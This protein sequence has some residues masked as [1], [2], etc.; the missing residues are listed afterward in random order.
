MCFIHIG[1]YFVT[2]KLLQR[3]RVE[4]KKNQHPRGYGV[5]IDADFISHSAIG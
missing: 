3:V 4:L 1:Y 5:L 2:G